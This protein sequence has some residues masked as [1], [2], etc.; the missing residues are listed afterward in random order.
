MNLSLEVKKFINNEHTGDYVTVVLPSELPVER[1][2]VREVNRD[3][4]AAHSAKNLADNKARIAQKAR[5]R[6]KNTQK[7][8]SLKEEELEEANAILEDIVSQQK[9]MQPELNEK[10]EVYE[11]AEAD[12]DE[13]NAAYLLK[14]ESFEAMEKA[15]NAAVEAE[16]ASSLVLNDCRAN[17]SGAENALASAKEQGIRHEGKLSSTRSDVAQ[18][19][20]LSENAAEE[21][22]E[23]S[24]LESEKTAHFNALSEETAQKLAVF[25]RENKRLADSQKALNSVLKECSRA[26]SELASVKEALAAAE[27]IASDPSKAD[28]DSIKAKAASLRA[29]LSNAEDRVEA[30]EAARKEAER[31]LEA[32]QE[33]NNISEMEYNKV[34]EL[35]S[36][37]RR[38]LD[39]LREKSSAASAK[40]AEA[41]AKYS[42]YS[43]SFEKSQN[44]LASSERDVK[45]FEGELI[46]AKKALLN[47]ETDVA[48]RHDD[49]VY[50]KSEMEKARAVMDEKRSVMQQ[51]EA[52]YNSLKSSYNNINLSYQ[53]AERDRKTQKNICERL[54]T[55]LK[56]LAS[57]LED[58]IAASEAADEDAEMTASEAERRRLSVRTINT[59]NETAKIHFMQQGKGEDIILIHSIGQSLYTYRELISRLSSK[60]RVTALDLVG[61]G[62]SQKP[63]YFNYTLDEMSDFIARFMDAMEM[64]S[65]HIFGFS[66][67]AGYVI[68]FAKR[69]PERVGKVVLLSPG[70]LTPEMPSSVRSIESRIFGG[71]AVRM[72]NMKAV[73]KMLSECYFDL[74]NHTEEVVEEYYKPI[75]NPET[76]RVIRACIANYDDEEVIHSLRD[77]NADTLI[78]WGNEDKWHPVDMANMFKA[79]MPKV[80]FTLVRN[81]GHLAHEEKAERVAQLIK[82]FIPCGYDEDGLDDY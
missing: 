82:M 79:V 41:Q 60:F 66:M 21:A 52:K 33:A 36:A 62:Y 57:Q 5:D 48:K 6:V 76:K 18:S 74:T 32:A 53:M 28:N 17:Y 38:E 63:Y 2:E 58:D 78:L 22:R 64:E 56:V 9:A 37:C 44:D 29:R 3:R 71:L 75:A 25:K 16:R 45:S 49:V 77:V 72:I 47:A 10:R 73:K 27:D 67:G 65:A 26:K 81:A 23:A 34:Y 35:M 55:E 80:N 12:Y 46:S 1:A 30:A 13:K 4:S 20:V 40:A 42:S 31:D 7:L 51:S 70:G 39:A 61:Y 43:S 68:N 50:T 59:K 54:K 15:Y 14:R 19:K 8:H 24:R 69:Y 11:E